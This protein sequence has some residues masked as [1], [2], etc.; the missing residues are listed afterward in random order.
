MDGDPIG[1]RIIPAREESLAG[2]NT[3]IASSKAHWSWPAGYL[4]TALPLHVVDPA[5]LRTNYCF[6]VLGARD[7]LAASFAVVASD[8]RVV[9][10]NL[11][12]TPGLIGKGIG[13]RACEH[14]F[15]LARERG[16]RELWMLPDPPAEGFYL[17]TGFSDTGEQVRSRVPGG[18][19]FSV[20]WLRLSTEQG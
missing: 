3:L 10:D 7:E 2:I 13:R 19:V 1:M 17:K 15:R 20:Y 12:V 4:E 6:E 11:W 14:I 8:A 5:Y 9:L 16:W 18:P